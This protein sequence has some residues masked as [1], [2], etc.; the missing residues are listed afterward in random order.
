MDLLVGD[1]Q[2]FEA[3]SGFVADSPPLSLRKMLDGSSSGVKIGVHLVRTEDLLANAVLVRRESYM[4]HTPEMEPKLRVPENLDLAPNAV[5]FVATDT[6]TGR[7]LGSMR[8]LTNL[9]RPLDFEQEVLLPAPYFG[10]PIALLQ[11]L[12]IVP[13][14]IGAEAKKHLFKAFYLYSLAMQAEWMFLYT[15]PP[16]DRLFTRLGFSPVFS[17]DQV[18]SGIFS[19]NREV[20]LLVAR[21]WDVETI[22]KETSPEWYDFFFRQYTPGIRVFDSVSNWTKHSRKTTRDESG[23]QRRSNS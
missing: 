6:E 13:G 18:V 19:D 21:L 5:V 15:P 8:G 17:G 7:V 14:S 23:R 11:R 2:P 3:T 9:S 4:R 16:R 20:R 10:R 22:L 12:S 1:D